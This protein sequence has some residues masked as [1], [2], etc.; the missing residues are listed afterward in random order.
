M[1]TN[2]ANL[3]D[4]NNVADG[5][6]YSL[7]VQLQD[8]YGN[9]IISAPSIGRQIDID[10]DAQN[11]VY[12]NQYTRAGDSA[13]FIAVPDSS[14]YNPYPI[15]NS[16][17]SYSDLQS[18][19]GN[20]EFSFRLYTPTYQYRVSHGADPS[21]QFLINTISYSVSDTIPE[22]WDTTGN[23]VLGSDGN[24]D[25]AFLPMFSNLFSGDLEN[26]D[27]EEDNL[28]RSSIAVDKN[29]SRPTGN[30]INRQMYLKYNGQSAAI[31]SY[32]LDYGTNASTSQTVATGATLESRF[33][34]GAFLPT[35]YNNLYTLLEQVG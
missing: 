1:P 4:D 28:Q 34:S 16:I 24:I 8:R 14:V 19:D 3:E 21:S 23:V 32:R 30:A 6:N 29:S 11:T 7:I 2:I 33:P 25:F 17:Q 18:S 27:F 15:G 10:I 31:N 20:Y 12:L 35:T 26:D 9:G 13:A 22:P 5:N